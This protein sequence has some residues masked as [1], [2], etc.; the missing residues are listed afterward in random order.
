[1]DNSICSLPQGNPQTTCS[2]YVSKHAGRGNWG[3]EYCTRKYLEPRKSGP[4]HIHSVK[5]KLLF[6]VAHVMHKAFHQKNMIG[7]AFRKIM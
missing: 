7:E 6:H 1:M 3:K 4:E 2:S 5:R